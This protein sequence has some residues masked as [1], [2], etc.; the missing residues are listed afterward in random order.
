MTQGLRECGE[1]TEQRE[2]TRWTLSAKP[3]GPT[4][5]RM[6]IELPFTRGVQSVGKL[7]M[8]QLERLYL[9]A[10]GL[11]AFYVFVLWAFTGPQ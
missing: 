5:R 4:R 1:L 10:A 6:P 8:R 7:T 9:L 2:T 11:M 3:N